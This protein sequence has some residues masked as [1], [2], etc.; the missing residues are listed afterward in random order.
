MNC[1]Y[2][3]KIKVKPGVWYLFDISPSI[4]YQCMDID[5]VKRYKKFRSLI[6]EFFLPFKP[7]GIEYEA[8]IE[9]GDWLGEYADYNQYPKLH[10]HCNIKMTEKGV[11]NFLLNHL[12]RALQY[13]RVK[14]D[15]INDWPLREEYI[16]K[17]SW[18]FKSLGLDPIITNSFKK[19]ESPLADSLGDSGDLQSPA[20]SE[21]SFH[22]SLPVQGKGPKDIFTVKV[23]RKRK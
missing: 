7:N 11:F 16:N 4:Q 22:E 14:L 21:N 1:P 10:V 23:S 17:Q 6:Y 8:H 3:D 13:G 5:P 2:H 15:V 12:P 20:L 19:L 9:V 18:L